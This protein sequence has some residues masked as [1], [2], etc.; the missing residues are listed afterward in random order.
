MLVSQKCRYALRA[1]FELALRTGEGPVKIGEIAQAQAIPSRF[2]EV[3]L[4]ELKQ[5]GF[6]RSQRGRKGGYVLA[7][8]PAGLA[9]GQIIR[10][11]EGPMGLVTCA[12]G[13]Q[14]HCPLRGGC[15]FLPMWDRVRDAM[16]DVYDTTT[17]Q[18][19]VDEHRRKQGK[20]VPS[21]AI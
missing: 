9:V 17:F 21:Y 8:E 2:L 5:G 3:I 1:I 11:I 15:V 18:D 12:S 7:H 6:T 14:T 19:L 20:Y 4:G 16:S 13:G 10:F